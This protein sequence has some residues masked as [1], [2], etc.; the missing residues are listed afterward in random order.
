MIAENRYALS[1]RGTSLFQLWYNQLAATSLP[2]S[3]AEP[4][5]II[6]ITAPANNVARPMIEYPA[7]IIDIDMADTNVNIVRNIVI[8]S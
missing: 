6:G 4:I 7:A 5:N 3:N 1:K 8:F 2:T